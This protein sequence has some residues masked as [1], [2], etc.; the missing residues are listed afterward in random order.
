MKPAFL[1]LICILAHALVANGQFAIIRDPDGF[2]NVRAD[3][4]AKAKIIG[5]FHDGDVFTSTYNCHG[6]VKVYYEPDEFTDKGYFEGY[7]YQDRLLSIEDLQHLPK[8]GRTLVEGHLT[9]HNDSVTVDLRTAPFQPKQHVIRKDKDGQ[10][11]KIDNKTFLG[12]DGS[13]PDQKLTSLRM[14]IRGNAVDI[15]AAAWNDVYEAHLT[16]CNVFF[17]TS[18]GFIYVYMP[19]CGDDAGAY[20]IVWIFKNGRYVKRYVGGY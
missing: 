9:L 14:T 6:W 3:S 15:P 19:S 16:T 4:S 2:T 17:D 12:T 5:Q 7:I 11:Q 20:E 8:N 18:T 13:M 10:V 1:W